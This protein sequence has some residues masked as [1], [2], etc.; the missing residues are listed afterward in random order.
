MAEQRLR[1]RDSSD[2]ARRLV[3]WDET[4]ADLIAAG[5]EPRFTLALRT[6]ALPPTAAAGI[7]HHALIS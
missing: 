4:L 7:I 2:F 3:A 5:G 6:D 1:Q